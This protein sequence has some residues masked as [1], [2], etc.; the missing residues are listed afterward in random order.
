MSRT[1]AAVLLLTV[2]AGAACTT[3]GQVGGIPV[4]TEPGEGVSVASVG[5]VPLSS[6]AGDAKGLV[7]CVVAAIRDK[8]PAVKTIPAD[9][10]L[11]ALFPSSR[12]R[13]DA[14]DPLALLLLRDDPAAR[15]RVSAAGI[16]YV[17]VLSGGSGLIEAEQGTSQIALGGVW[18]RRSAYDANI[19][20]VGSGREIGTASAQAEATGGVGIGLIPPFLYVVPTLTH[21]RA[22]AR[23]GA[24]VVE[25][26]GGPPAAK[27]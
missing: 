16:R 21:S 22:C 1:L 5:D 10:L 15:Q 2:A 19:Y 11:K 4:Q 20:D 13:A 14:M 23:L 18:T 27:D 24:V 17:I 9:V 7:S 8:L 26:L 6:S 25:A 12:T 3:S